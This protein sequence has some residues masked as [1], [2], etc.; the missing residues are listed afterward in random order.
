MIITSTL[1]STNRSFIRSTQLFYSYH[2]KKN[3]RY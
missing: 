1:S 3:K 2:L